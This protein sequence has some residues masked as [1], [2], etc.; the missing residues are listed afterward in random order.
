MSSLWWPPKPYGNIPSP[1]RADYED[2]LRQ[3]LQRHAWAKD[4][5]FCLGIFIGNE[6]EWPDTFTPMVLGL[7]DAHPTKAW[8]RKTLGE[9]DLQAAANAGTIEPLYEDFA[10]AFFAKS[11]AVLQ[12]VLPGK[13]FLGCRTHRGPN[14]LG[15]AALGHVD[16][17]SVNVYD[18]QA[19]HWQVGEDTDIPVLVGEFHFGAP[20]RGVPSPGLSSAWDQTQRG[21]AFAHYLASALAS[22]KLV[23]VHWF[24]WLD[25]SAAGRFDRENHQCGFVDVTGRCYPEFTDILTRASRAMY[26]ACASGEADRM[27][28]LEQL[29][30]R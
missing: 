1:F 9:S 25:Q 30:V 22:D 23:G 21:Y 2:D 19:R 6:L 13:L 18:S 29:L 28:V 17:F 26:P 10:R 11:K 7:P 5:P 16:V 12:E 8:V 15:R 24:R 4:D 27:R 14:V 20:D 3:A